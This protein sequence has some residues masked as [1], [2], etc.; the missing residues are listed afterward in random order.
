M[1][2]KT[3]E[4]SKHELRYADSLHKKLAAEA[5]REGLTNGEMLGVILKAWYYSKRSIIRSGRGDSE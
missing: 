4:K 3:V 1:P 5:K 2:K